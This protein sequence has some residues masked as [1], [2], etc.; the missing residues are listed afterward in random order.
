MESGA[1]WAQYHE[2]YVSFMFHLFWMEISFIIFI[3]PIPKIGSL[4]WSGDVNSDKIRTCPFHKKRSTTDNPIKIRVQKISAIKLGKLF[5][6]NQKKRMEKEREAGEGRK[7][8]AMWKTR[9]E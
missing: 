4:V 3:R 1:I 2:T 6:N 9:R 5:N 7:E 8:I